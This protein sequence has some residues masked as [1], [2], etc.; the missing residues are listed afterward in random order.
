MI[1]LDGLRLALAAAAL[2]L[3]VWF[4]RVKAARLARRA[5]SLAEL[6]EFTRH[7][8]VQIRMGG[9]ALPDALGEC[10]ARFQGRWVERYAGELARR[11]HAQESARGLWLRALEALDGDEPVSL[12]GEDKALIGLFGDQLAGHD[13]RAIAENFTY[14]HER[15]AARIE[16]AE[17]ES[18]AKG[19]LYRTVGSLAGLACAIVIA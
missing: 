12:A 15:L 6:M 9:F 17:Q 1:P 19:K 10:A 7:L 5:A 4:G 11:Y 2:A 18:K 8:E 13:L 14:L 3:G 16:A